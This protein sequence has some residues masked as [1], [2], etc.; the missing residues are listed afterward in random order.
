MKNFAA[1]KHME[2]AIPIQVVL[3]LS[4]N[5]VGTLAIEKL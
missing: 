1:C 4:Q 3:K 5:M 2:R